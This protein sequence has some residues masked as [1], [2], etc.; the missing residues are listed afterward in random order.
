MRRPP[1]WI[2]R[3]GPTHAAQP[4][5]NP[6]D[7]SPPSW[8]FKSSS[9]TLYNR[10]AEVAIAVDA[11]AEQGS[12]LGWRSTTSFNRGEGQCGVWLEPALVRSAGQPLPWPWL[13]ARFGARLEA[14]GATAHSVRPALAQ[15]EVSPLCRMAATNPALAVGSTACRR[16]G[17]PRLPTKRAIVRVKPAATKRL[18]VPRSLSCERCSIASMQRVQFRALPG[19]RVAAMWTDRPRSSPVALL[20]RGLERWP[21]PGIPRFRR[22]CTKVTGSKGRVPGIVRKELFMIALASATAACGTA[23]TSSPTPDRDS[24]RRSP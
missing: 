16:A 11:G 15:L 2:R 4:R 23:P 12:P 1:R 24:V 14:P 9:G 13:H 8:S 19:G 3:V 6:P 18:S 5:R 22:V 7:L 17:V 20:R 21:A 10:M